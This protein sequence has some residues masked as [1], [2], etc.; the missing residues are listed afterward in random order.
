MLFISIPILIFFIGWLIWYIALPVSIIFA[1]GVIF[2]II[3]GHKMHASDSSGNG[4][5]CPCIKLQIRS[6]ILIAV[7]ALVWAFLAGQGGLYYQGWDYNWRNAIFRDLVTLKWPVVYSQTNTALVYYFTYWMVPASIGKIAML[8]TNPVNAFFVASISLLIYTTIGLIIIFLLAISYFKAFSSKKI[9]ILLIII[10]FFSGLDILAVLLQ[11]Y[12]QFSMQA[13]TRL[14]WWAGIYQYSANTTLLD[15]VFNQTVVPWMCVLLIIQEKDIKNMALIGLCML[16]FAPLP[17]FGM[18]PYFIMFGIMFLIKALKSNRSWPKGLLLYIKDIFSIPN[19]AAIITVF[20]VYYL[21]YNMNSSVSKQPLRFD[22]GPKYALLHTLFHIGFFCFIEFGIYAI[23]I[24]KHYRKEVLFYVT[25]VT[26]CVIP[27]F[28]IGGGWDFCMRA[29]I[30]GLF[31]LMLLIIKYLFDNVAYVTKKLVC[32]TGALLLSVALV[33]GAVTPCIDFK[34]GFLSV[35]QAKKINLVN[36]TI[37]SFN[38][39]EAGKDNGNSNFLITDP[40]EKHF[41]KFLAK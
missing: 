11:P 24:F 13:P 10:V 2:Y 14:E 29:S 27:M 12:G 23:I 38:T 5:D 1:I 32:S 9:A 37:K 16:A 8:F 31:F 34:T 19:L 36:D 40:N 15:F 28:F 4:L 25:V 41:F 17:F 30:P 20:P 18:I 39:V 33:I 35:W 6:L 21:F 3:N 7:V 26:L 22:L